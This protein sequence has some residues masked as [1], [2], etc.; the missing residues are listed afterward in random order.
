MYNIQKDTMF[1]MH[2]PQNISIHFTT[3]G[4]IGWKNRHVYYRV[5]SPPIIIKTQ[6]NLIF[7]LDGQLRTNVKSMN[8]KNMN[9]NNHANVFQKN[10]HFHIA[11]P[12]D[13]PPQIPNTDVNSSITC[14]V[15]NF[16]SDPKEIDLTQNAH[17]THLIDQTTQTDA[18]NEEEYELSI[19]SSRVYNDGDDAQS[20]LYVCYSDQQT[21]FIHLYENPL[22]MILDENNTEFVL[23]NHI[24]SDDC[25]MDYIYDNTVSTIHPT[26][27]FTY[28][29]QQTIKHD[30]LQTD[31]K[32][33]NDSELISIRETFFMDGMTP[34]HNEVYRNNR[35]F[36]LKNPNSDSIIPTPGE[37][38]I[39]YKY[40]V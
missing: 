35:W 8:F 23:D 29:K 4:N 14:S 28:E 9:I 36:L 34:I 5:P 11:I 32:L 1:K 10:K 6:S 26:S 19:D 22:H 18:I 24:H 39:T 15:D 21:P 16:K 2:T 37:C 33:K 30:E 25:E 17:K 20:D 12:I 3:I 31:I 7:D 40:D 38:F 13:S 27:H